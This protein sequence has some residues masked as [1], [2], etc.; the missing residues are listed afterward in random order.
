MTAL[1]PFGLT[2]PQLE[3]WCKKQGL[4][5]YRGRQLA[6][7]MYTHRET[8]FTRMT[9]LP[10]DVRGKWQRDLPFAL[11]EIELE[12]ESR[13]GTVKWRVAMADGEAVETVI[14]PMRAA[15]GEKAERNTAC[16]STQ[17]G[18]ALG[19]TFCATATLGLRRN[20]TASEI[21]GQ[22]LLVQRHLYPRRLTNIVFM[23]MGEP[24]HNYDAV[25]QAI[26]VITGQPGMELGPG[27]ITVSTVGL[28]PEI[29]RLAESGLGVKLAISLNATTDQAR[30]R[31]MPVNRRF[32]LKDLMHAAR[33]YAEVT[34]RRVTFEYVLLQ[35]ENDL[36][37]D[38]RRLA[39]LIHDVPCKINLI[40]YNP[41][42]QM[43]F[44][45]PAQDRLERFRDWLY[46]RCPAVTVRYSKGLDIEAACGQLVAVKDAQS[47]SGRS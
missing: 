22:V 32:G 23:G 24:L 16:L 15:T 21:A 31:T 36:P 11:P 33:K 17:V 2:I 35:G 3:A 38:A 44:K 41:N 1:H 14:M 7:W 27:R 40:P 43:S 47:R 45:R 46:P 39:G 42:P 13:D 12:R 10:S 9:D 19:C 37:E 4:P 30:S 8:D 34:D 25:T 6:A 28:V 20:L 18:C 5:S 26:A 29:Y